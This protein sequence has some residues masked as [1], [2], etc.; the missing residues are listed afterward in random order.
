MSLRIVFACSYFCR[1]CHH[2]QYCHSSKKES[3]TMNCKYQFSYSNILLTFSMTSSHQYSSATRKRKTRLDEYSGTPKL[4]NI[5]LSYFDV[6]WF[7][8][9]IIL[10]FRCELLLSRNKKKKESL[11]I[12]RD[13]WRKII[14]F[15]IWRGTKEFLLN[16]R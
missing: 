15:Y 9:L 13:L 5:S 3:F 7:L 11:K 2:I 16:C 14:C 8:M 4:H 6:Y 12:R 1:S 10:Q